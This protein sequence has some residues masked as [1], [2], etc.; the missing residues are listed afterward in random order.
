MSREEQTRSNEN[1]F[2]QVNLKSFEQ[3]EKNNFESDKLEIRS[4][5]MKSKTGQ[6]KTKT[7]QMKT[8]SDQVEMDPIEYNSCCLSKWRTLNMIKRN[9]DLVEEEINQIKVDLVKCMSCY[10]SKLNFSF[11]MLFIN[12]T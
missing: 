10:L 11:E 1:R 9:V 3:I 2:S 6:V 5:E 7:N 8:K 12:Y 4:G